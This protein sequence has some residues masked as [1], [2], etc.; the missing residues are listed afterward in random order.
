MMILI[1]LK[2]FFQDLSDDGF[3]VKFYNEDQTK[4]G[5]PIYRIVIKSDDDN[6]FDINDCLS[7]LKRSVEYMQIFGYNYR[8]GYLPKSGGNCRFFVSQKGAF[9]MGHEIDEKIYR[10][11]VSFY[12]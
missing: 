11:H 3:D 9:H 4:L 5:N 10:I 2:I 6:Y 1:N 12:L 8:C 7:V